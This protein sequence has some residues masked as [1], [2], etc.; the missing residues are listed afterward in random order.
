MMIEHVFNK[1]EEDKQEDFDEETLITM[2]TD[3]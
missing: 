2:G 3:K 1:N